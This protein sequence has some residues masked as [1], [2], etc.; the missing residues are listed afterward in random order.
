MDR[1]LF[2]EIS[3]LAKANRRSIAK[4]I[5]HAVAQY[6]LK[7]KESDILELVGQEEQLS[8]EKAMEYLKKLQELHTRYKR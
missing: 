3:L 7:Q 8:S 1:K 5:E 6:I 2:E 4:E